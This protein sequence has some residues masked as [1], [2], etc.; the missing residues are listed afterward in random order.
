[1]IEIYDCMKVKAT[2]NIKKGELVYV[3]KMKTL[4]KC[5]P[6]NKPVGM[7]NNDIKKGSI[8]VFNLYYHLC[9]QENKK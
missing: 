8:E 1:M 2:Q 7:A 5:G 9:Y 6:N 4:R 3:T